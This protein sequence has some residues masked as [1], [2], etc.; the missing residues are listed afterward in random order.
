MR[1]AGQVD[2]NLL[3]DPTNI[4]AFRKVNQASWYVPHAY[5]PAVHKP[6]PVDPDLAC[7]FAFV[8]TGYPSRI[9]FF[10][11]VDWRDWRVT[12]AGN[13]QWTK[14][15]SPLRRFIGHDV[16][17]CLPNSETV[18]LY[19][20]CKASA[21]VYRRE[22]ERPEWSEGWAMGPREVELAASGTFFL[23]E[24]REEGNEVLNM[25]PTFRSPDEFG[26]V[27]GWWLKHD[28]ERETAAQLARE[29]IAGRTFVNHAKGLLRKL[30]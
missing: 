17:E 3:N 28:M 15:D 6:G 7:D 19:Q 22:A 24:P 14:P 13:W 30:G 23:R 20:S 21:N 4:E 12:F 11:Q 16:E 9:Q 27:L 29:A 1:L 8:G 5:D 26:D 10:E 2:F 18:R 25:L